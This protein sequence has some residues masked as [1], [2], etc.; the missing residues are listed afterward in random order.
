MTDR[1]QQKKELRAARLAEER[2]AAGR[3]EFRRRLIVALGIGLGVAAAAF[4]LGSGGDVPD[5]LPASYLAFRQQP[6]AC[7]AIAP[8]EEQLFDFDAAVDQGLGSDPVIATITTSCGPILIELDPDF[9]GTVNSF[10]FLARQGYYDGTAIHR[11]APG[12]VIQGGDP[13]ADGSGGPGYFAP[14]EFP[15]AG[16]L[17]EP[18]VVAM[19][20][21]GG[22][23]TGSQFFIVIGPDASV[24]RNT[25]SILGR[26]IEGQAAI[27]FIAAVPTGPV[28]GSTE[29]SRPLES[30]YIESVEIATGN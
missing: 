22:A 5:R 8:P 9:P 20:N 14:D 4:F 29:R 3:R 13:A 2:K 1:R 11:V 24:L 21:A 12:F 7:G 25:F 6:T 28:P 19:A 10:V 18:G 26:V 27:D 23:T 16:F 30:V 17:Y 15:P